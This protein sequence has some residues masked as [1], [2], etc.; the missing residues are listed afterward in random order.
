[1]RVQLVARWREAWKWGSVRWAL[2]LGAVAALE[3]QLPTLE[4]YLPQHW[5]SYM[6]LAVVGARLLLVQ[7]KQAPGTLAASDEARSVNGAM[8]HWH[9]IPVHVTGEVVTHKDNWP[10]I[11]DPGPATKVGGSP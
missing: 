9:G 10:L 3:T 1:M 2:L 4:A 7:A 8:L 6:A 11:D 5:V